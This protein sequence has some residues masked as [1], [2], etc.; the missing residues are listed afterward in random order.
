MHS[1]I[2][3]KNKLKLKTELKNQKKIVHHTHDS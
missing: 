1:Y 2:L 3:I